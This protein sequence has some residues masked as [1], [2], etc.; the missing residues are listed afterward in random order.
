[1]FNNDLR[2]FPKTLN[3]TSFSKVYL[4]GNPIDCNCDMLWFAEF[5]NTTHLKS[6]RR[7]VKD[8]DQVLCVGGKWNG[9]Q[10]YKMNAEQMDCFPKILA[11]SV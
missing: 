7:I 4:S 8:Y 9:T 3:G 11:K 10:V 6:R 1:M 5:L 2:T